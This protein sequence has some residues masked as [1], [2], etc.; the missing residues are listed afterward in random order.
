MLLFAYKLHENASVSIYNFRVF[1]GDMFEIIDGDPD[2]RRGREKEGEGKRK[3]K[4]RGR[5]RKG[6]GMGKGRER[7]EKRRGDR[8]V[9]E[10]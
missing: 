10:G 4:G 5:R 6:K 2:N 3:G 9:R 8:D 1:S 7:G